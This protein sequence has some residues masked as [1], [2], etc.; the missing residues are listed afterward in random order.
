MICPTCHQLIDEPPCFD[1]RETVSIRGEKYVVKDVRR[2]A[3]PMSG[4]RYR[5]YV[6][7]AIV[8]RTTPPKE[9]TKEPSDLKKWMQ[10]AR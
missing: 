7:L 2:L 6:P 3:K 9:S 4:K 8:E 1:L 5:R 10:E